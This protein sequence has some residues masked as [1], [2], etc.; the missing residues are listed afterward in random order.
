[1]T[2]PVITPA[3]DGTTFNPDEPHTLL[4]PHEAATA[5]GVP[6]ETVRRWIAQQRIPTYR[7]GRTVWVAE[8]HIID[9]EHALRKPGIEARRH[10]QTT[11]T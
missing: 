6:P 4:R 5:I 2:A 8:D 9:L 3:A 11:T 1:M 10:A 7:E